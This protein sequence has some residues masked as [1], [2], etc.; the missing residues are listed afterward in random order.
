MDDKTFVAKYVAS[1]SER[2]NQSLKEMVAKEV[3]PT[4]AEKDALFADMEETL[5]KLTGALE[6][7]T[8]NMNDLMDDEEEEIPVA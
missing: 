7:L 6:Y 2:L 8:H 1:E 5:K 3:A 4:D